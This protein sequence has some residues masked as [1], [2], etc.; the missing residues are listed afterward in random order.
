[1]FS[2]NKYSNTSF[3][4]VPLS[5]DNSSR[6]Y[7]PSDVGSEFSPSI[8]VSTTRAENSPS[9]YTSSSAPGIKES[10]TMIESNHV[11]G[12]NSGRTK[13]TA[14]VCPV[15]S[16]EFPSMSMEDF[17]QHVFECIDDGDD[18]P[19]QTLQNPTMDDTN[20]IDRICPMCNKSFANTLPLAEFK[21]HVQDHFNEESIIDRFE[22]LHP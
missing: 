14:H 7:M 10:T 15:C 3:N 9:V 11:T 16:R 13:L 18:K 8:L 1:M 17:Q 12:N 4:Y 19:L 2:N 22:V 21:K 20:G 6:P 5:V